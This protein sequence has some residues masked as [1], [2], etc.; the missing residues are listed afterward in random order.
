MTSVHSL[1]AN[2]ERLELLAAEMYRLL[3][4]RFAAREPVRE[5]F[6]RLGA[7]EI[8]H[9]S[10]V[11]LLAAQYRNDPWLFG[12]AVL[13]E[14][15]PDPAAMLRDLEGDVRALEAGA[16]GN[17]LSQVRGRIL[18]HERRCV[19]FHT[20]F[21][22]AGAPPAIASFFEE[23]ARQDEEHERLLGQL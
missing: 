6:A 4:E 12:G 17:D 1:F 18:E 22:V 14:G 21:M 7:E 20:Q 5:L 3:A 2:A 23:L 9:A 13:F 15:T 19:S 10:R 8:Q 16:W 11:R